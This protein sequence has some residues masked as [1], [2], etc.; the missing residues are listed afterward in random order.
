MV[1]SVF[2][3]ETS[4]CPKCHGNKTIAIGENLREPCTCIGIALL[5]EY[6]SPLK[7][8]HFLKSTKLLEPLK[9]R[10]NLC[11]ECEDNGIWQAHLRTALI[12]RKMPEKSWKIVSP[13]ELMSHAVP[14]GDN[15]QQ[16]AALYSVD[17]LSINA[18]V[19]LHYEKAS[20]WHE[21]VIS[22]RQSAG[23]PTWIVVKSRPQFI[24]QHPS[25]TSSFRQLVLNLPTM[26]LT[27]A[28]TVD[29]IVKSKTP[30]VKLASGN[31]IPGV[32]VTLLD[33]LPEMDDRINYLKEH[34]NE[35][36]RKASINNGNDLES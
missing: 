28:N 8:F 22:N 18:P 31:G 16:M 3:A 10:T 14:S 34:V 30:Q 19:F 33:F 12:R 4:V 27:R 29:L 11:I 1:I 7:D 23:H 20:Q 15:A 13:T 2:S 24:D 25:M 32:D 35:W 9:A 6:T 5:K 36:K 17:L 26:K 21:F